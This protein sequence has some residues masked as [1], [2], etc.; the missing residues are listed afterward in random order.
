MFFARVGG[1]FAKQRGI[2]GAFFKSTG[3]LLLIFKILLYRELIYW[4][5]K[6]QSGGFFIGVP[7][8]KPARVRIETA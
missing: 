2:G 7:V 8:K 6:N 3:Y 5:M 1:E 4:L